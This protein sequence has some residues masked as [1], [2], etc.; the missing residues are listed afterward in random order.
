MRDASSNHIWALVYLPRSHDAEG[1]RETAYKQCLAYSITVAYKLTTMPNDVKCDAR[2]H[3]HTYRINFVKM[4][5]AWVRVCARP[6]ACLFIFHVSIATAVHSSQLRM[7]NVQSKHVNNSINFVAECVRASTVNCIVE[8][9][10]I[11][12]RLRTSNTHNKCMRGARVD[13]P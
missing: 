12:N 13:C 3:T 7:H 4:K 8:I 10:L 1:D 5:M 2:M 9:Y 6:F 11:V